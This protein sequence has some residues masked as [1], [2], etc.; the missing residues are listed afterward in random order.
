M[1]NNDINNY[2]RLPN[3]KWVKVIWEKYYPF[4]EVCGSIENLENHHWAPR[5]LFGDSAD[6]YPIS[7]LCKK[8]HL[9]WH[10]IVTPNMIEE[11][12]IKAA[13]LR[14]TNGK[15]KPLNPPTHQPSRV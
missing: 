15:N 13:E 12:K 6:L 7:L 2:K 4:C 8:C 11:G 1:I 3:G 9:E 14:I 5:H 10:S